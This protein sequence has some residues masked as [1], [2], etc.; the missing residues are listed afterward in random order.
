M[1]TT[2]DIITPNGTVIQALPKKADTFLV[3]NHD[4]VHL[5]TC[6]RVRTVYVNPWRWAEG[7]PADEIET[8]KE[9]GLKFCRTC[10]P[11]GSVRARGN[12]REEDE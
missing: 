1:S 7:L 12:A 3:R 11:L 10:D 4:M 5:K 2:G 9:N 6:Y 8:A